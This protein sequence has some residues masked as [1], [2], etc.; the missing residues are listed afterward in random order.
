MHA[1]S[2]YLHMGWIEPVHVQACT[3]PDLILPN[4]Y[5]RPTASVEAL[6]PRCLHGT[7]Q[8]AAHSCPALHAQVAQLPANDVTPKRWTKS[9]SNTNMD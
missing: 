9:Q 4:A 5:N 1:S 8:V 7:D 6:A 2:V 3:L